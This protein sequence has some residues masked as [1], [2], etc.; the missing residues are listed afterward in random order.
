MG[1]HC[2]IS[3]TTSSGKLRTIGQYVDTYRILGIMAECGHNNYEFTS[4]LTYGESTI[5]VNID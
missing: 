3:G 4:R 2:L 5:P 1:R